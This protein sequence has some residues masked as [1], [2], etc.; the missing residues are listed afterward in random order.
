M[1]PT[2]I[3]L[4]HET[5]ETMPRD[6]DIS[7]TYLEGNTPLPALSFARIG[8][9][10]LL[11]VSQKALAV[12]AQHFCARTTKYRRFFDV[13]PLRVIIDYETEFNYS[14]TLDVVAKN[15]EQLSKEPFFA[16]NIQRDKAQNL[17]LRFQPSGASVLN[18][19]DL[20]TLIAEEFQ[21]S[22]I[23]FDAATREPRVLTAYPDDAFSTFQYIIVHPHTQRRLRGAA[24]TGKI[25]RLSID[26]HMYPEELDF[27]AFSAIANRTVTNSDPQTIYIVPLQ[28]SAQPESTTNLVLALIPAQDRG[29]VDFSVILSIQNLIDHFFD[30]NFRQ[31]QMDCI[32]WQ[33]DQMER[34]RRNHQRSNYEQLFRQFQD[35]LEQ[36]GT[37]VLESTL[38][39]S[40]ACLLFDP[41]MSALKRILVVETSDQPGMRTRRARFNS[42]APQDIIPLSESH[43]FISAYAFN[44]AHEHPHI[45]IDNVS[46][47][48]KKYRGLR[49]IE[50]RRKE[51]AG[52]PRSGAPP[53]GKAA[54]M[55]RPFVIVGGTR[56]ELSI[57]LRMAEIPFAVINI[58]SFTVNGLASSQHFISQVC[59]NAGLHLDHLQQANDF[60]WLMANLEIQE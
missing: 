5:L 46:M 13:S 29:T 57:P 2:R 26:E 24:R 56:C 11:P 45:Y 3:E 14:H 1:R 40:F 9:T 48:Q 4:A 60:H 37:R 43:R 35:Y 28:N 18:I 42:V 44:K 53:D 41:S 39:H 15:A 33:I 58:E 36:V 25:V 52:V 6:A 32:Y 49:S 12:T 19:R 30:R 47:P 21:L 17:A 7:V 54:F 23:C 55:S 16:R 59:K 50:V 8:K 22:A 20:I 38:A 27:D 51:R 34:V 10:V 31:N